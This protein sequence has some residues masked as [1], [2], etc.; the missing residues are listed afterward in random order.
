MKYR[1]M[2]QIK[3]QD[4]DKLM[5]SFTSIEDA[6]EYVTNLNETHRAKNRSLTTPYYIHFKPNLVILDAVFEEDMSTSANDDVV[7]F[8]KAA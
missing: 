2:K 4:K 6:R 7:E 1:V 5:K 8:R 3:T